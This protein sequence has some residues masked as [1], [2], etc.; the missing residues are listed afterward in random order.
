VSLFVGLP[1]SRKG[2]NK[3]H[4]KFHV[5]KAAVLIYRLMP[6]MLGFGGP[7]PTLEPLESVAVLGLRVAFKDVYSTDILQVWYHSIDIHFFFI[8]V[9]FE[10]WL[11]IQF[12]KSGQLFTKIYIKKS[13]KS[14]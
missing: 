10:D 8:H 9:Q 7:L 14:F 5:K 6:R 3:P 1:F 13:W 4:L 11:S 12:L 2:D